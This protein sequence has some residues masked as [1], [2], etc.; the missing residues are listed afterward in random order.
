MSEEE[1]SP[2]TIAR[3]DHSSPDKDPSSQDNAPDS[4]DKEL[5][6]TTEVK[7]TEEATEP[8]SAILLHVSNLTRYL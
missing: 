1:G 2:S 8:K 6:S 7:V 3:K 4:M 5:P